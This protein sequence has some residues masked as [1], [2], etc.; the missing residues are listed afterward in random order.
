MLLNTG[1]K[2]MELKTIFSEGKKEWQRRRAI[3]QD[4][5][6]LKEKNTVLSSQMISLGK[7]AWDEKVDISNAPDIKKMLESQ[8]A[9]IDD[10][11]QKSETCNKRKEEKEN[12]KT[13]KNEQFNTDRKKIE[14]KKKAIDTRLN[15]EKDQLKVLQKNL[16][17]AE[18]RSAQICK[19]RE[20]LQQK[21]T[22]ANVNEDQKI[23]FKKTLEDLATEESELLGS[24]TNYNESI[25]AQNDKIEPLQTEVNELQKQINT[26]MS[27]QKETISDI[28][29]TLNEIRKELDSHITQLKEIDHHQKEQFQLLGASLAAGNNPSALLSS[30]LSAIRVTEQEIKEIEGKIADLG[31]QAS[32]ESSSAYKKMLAIIIGGAVLIIAIIVTAV[33]LLAPKNKNPLEELV[34][35]NVPVEAIKDIAAKVLDGKAIEQKEGEDTFQQGVN[36]IKEESEKKIGKGTPVATEKDLAAVLTSVPGWEMTPSAFSSMSFSDIETA[37]LRTTYKNSDDQTVQVE[38]SDT[39]SVAVLLAP[40]QA[41]FM[42]NMTVDDDQIYQKSGK[43]NGVP[44]IESLEKETGTARLILVIKERYLVNLETNVDKG[45]DI[46]KQFAGQLNLNALK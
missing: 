3:S 8:Q 19:E 12:E 33:I 30:E 13:K 40:S 45:L 28:D 14:E 37:N 34:K 36:A 46:L 35:G 39:H 44:M 38:I 32:E 23:G 21:V 42:M 29:K 20:Q 11:K 1:G 17:Q 4:N 16:A 15:A 9:Q 2:T 6:A 10:L 25:K 7:K 24:L 5:S 31:S 22:D 43:Q 18:T 26:I 27:Q 41:M